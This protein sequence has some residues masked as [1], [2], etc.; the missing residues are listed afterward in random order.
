MTSIRHPTLFLS[1]GS[2]MLAVQDSP[3]GRFLDGLGSELPRPA[4]VVVASAHFMALHPSIGAAR[5]PE[6]VHDFGGF[7]RQLYEIQYPAPGAV[8]LAA[9]IASRMAAVGFQAHERPNHG[10]DHGVWVPLRRMYPQADIPLVP[11]SVNPKEDAKHHYDVGRALASLRDQGVLVVGSGG[12]VHNLG[13][14]DWQHPEAPMPGWARDFAEWMRGRLEADDL[15]A[16][17]D[18]EQQA[19][20]ARRAHPI[21][22]HLMPLFVALGAAGASPAVRTLHR[23]HEFGSLALDAFA[24]D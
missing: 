5:R 9:D 17:L 7:P 10:I 11:I 3:A 22:E 14:L 6:T 16:L 12:F 19:P 8:E 1:H 13:D 20:N 24:F 23:S 2:P 15:P 4:A 18:W 21:L